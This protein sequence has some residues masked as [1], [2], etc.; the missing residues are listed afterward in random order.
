[1][2]PVRNGTSGVPR[3]TSVRNLYCSCLTG[4]ANVSS[5]FSL[6]G[7]SQSAGVAVSTARAKRAV[8]FT[9]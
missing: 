1:M 6:R 3:A 4:S 7:I 2:L 5:W 8:D 9:R